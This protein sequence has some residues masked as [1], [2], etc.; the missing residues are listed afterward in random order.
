MKVIFLVINVQYHILKMAGQLKFKLFKYLKAPPGWKCP[1][2]FKLGLGE[3][4]E[5]ESES[6][7][8][9]ETYA[10]VQTVTSQ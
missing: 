8:N 4:W 10:K 9:G 5:N 3:P 7:S 2:Q 1:K 6:S